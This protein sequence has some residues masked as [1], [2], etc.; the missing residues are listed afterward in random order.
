MR[1][2]VCKQYG[3]MHADLLLLRHRSGDALRP[4]VLVARRAQQIFQQAPH[5]RSV[6]AFARSLRILLAVQDRLHSIWC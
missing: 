1:V 4:L 5:R 2:H 6:R 3:G